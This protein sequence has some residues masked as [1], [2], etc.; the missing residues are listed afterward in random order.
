MAG[1]RILGWQ[2][3]CSNTSSA[4]GSRWPSPSSR[5]PAAAG[6]APP[7]HSCMWAACG[8]PK[9]LPARVVVLERG[10]GAGQAKG[11]RLFCSARADWNSSASLRRELVQH[12]RD[13]F[14]VPEGFSI[15]PISGGAG[16]TQRTFADGLTGED[17]KG[18][19][20]EVA[21]F[22]WSTG[23][24]LS[25]LLVRRPFPVW[26]VFVRSIVARHLP[27]RDSSAVLRSRFRMIRRECVQVADAWLHT[28]EVALPRGG[29]R[30]LRGLDRGLLL[31]AF[32]LLCCASCPLLNVDANCSTAHI[33][34]SLPARACA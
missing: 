19:A 12:V 25:V 29:W 8:F 11:W 6:A 2:L 34:A 21:G 28:V 3:G 13:A 26:H 9:R 7:R 27:L 4:T 22:L 32:K 10:Q 23:L 15:P 5:A 31:S 18:R 16:I 17:L 14:G 30:L 20:V 24:R 1:N 33:Y